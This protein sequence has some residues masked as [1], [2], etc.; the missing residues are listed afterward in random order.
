[1]L[2]RSMATAVALAED[3]SVAKSYDVEADILNAK[4]RD[5]IFSPDTQEQVLCEVRSALWESA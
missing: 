1:M 3:S 2:S 5:F 4:L